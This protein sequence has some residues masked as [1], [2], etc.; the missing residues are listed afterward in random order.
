MAEK[1]F[2]DCWYWAE[3]KKL[4]AAEV[5][6]TGAFISVILCRAAKGGE[7]STNAGCL[8]F[9]SILT[10]MFRSDAID[11]ELEPAFW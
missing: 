5:E 9:E 3:D 4:A 10:F 8:P 6:V 2:S 11:I 7:L 1:F